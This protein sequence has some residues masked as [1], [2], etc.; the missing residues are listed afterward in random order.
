MT[1][2]GWVVWAN[3]SQLLQQRQRVIVSASFERVFGMDKATPEATDVIDLLALDGI[4]PSKRFILSAS[5]ERY[6][7]IVGTTEGPVRCT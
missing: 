2:K 1:K 7:R 6:P 3:F 5:S 4:T